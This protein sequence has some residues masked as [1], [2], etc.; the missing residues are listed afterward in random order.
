MLCLFCQEEDL[1]GEVRR[2]RK[3]ALS[4]S[5]RKSSISSTSTA[6]PLTTPTTSYHSSLMVAMDGEW[7]SPEKNSGF[8]SIQDCV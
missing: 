2:P 7:S 5:S 8:S 6:R 4:I 3:R 1:D